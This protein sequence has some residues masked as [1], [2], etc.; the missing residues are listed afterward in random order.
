[1]ATRNRTKAFID[2]REAFKTPEQRA[3]KPKK[4]DE[5]MSNSELLAVR[6]AITA[7][8][9]VDNMSKFV[10]NRLGMLSTGKIPRMFRRHGLKISIK[11]NKTS[12]GYNQRVI[13]SNKISDTFHNLSFN[14]FL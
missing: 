13:C 5:E 7:F 3:R 2:L 9:I 14:K 8:H 6:S 4:D 1:M 10:Y 12:L 11:L